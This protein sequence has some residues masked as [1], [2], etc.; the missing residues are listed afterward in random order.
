[1]RDFVP[2]PILF[3]WG[4][5]FVHLGAWHCDSKSAAQIN[6]NAL[7]GDKLKVSHAGVVKALV[8]EQGSIFRHGVTGN[9]L[10]FAGEDLETYFNFLT[11]GALIFA[12]APMVES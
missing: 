6:V 9:A 8:G 10:A 5:D 12:K 3:G 7:F 11:D 1:M 4:E 2:S